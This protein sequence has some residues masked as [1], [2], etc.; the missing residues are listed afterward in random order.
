METP[1]TNPANELIDLGQLTPAQFG[2][3]MSHRSEREAARL[4][5]AMHVDPAAKD[6]WATLHERCQ[7]LAA[8]WEAKLVAPVAA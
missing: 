3:A 4:C 8:L 7:K 2:N 1:C 5:R 6:A